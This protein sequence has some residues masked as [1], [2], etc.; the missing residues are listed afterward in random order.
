[1]SNILLAAP[2][3]S[4]G[5]SFTGSLAAGDMS[6]QNLKDISL[7]KKY[8]TEDL[9]ATIN[10][11]LLSA[12]EIDFVSIVA[13]N[14]TASGSVTIK[15]GTTSAVSDFSTGSLDLITGNDAGYSRKFFAS[16][17]SAQTYR[18]WQLSFSDASNTDGYLEMG[19]VYLSKSFQPNTNASYGMAEGHTDQSRV[20]RTASGGV[21]AVTRT[22]FQVATVELDFA[23]KEEMYGQAF[24][25][26]LSRGKS[27]D[28]V[29]VPDMDDTDYFQKRFVYGKFNEINPIVNTAFG[30]YRKRYRIE[31]IR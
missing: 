18:Y 1:M 25:I 8:R 29:F 5:G 7:Y 10:I 19:R 28:V 27:G 15:A 22:P 6:L 24:D 16:K 20:S 13:H 9:S 21:S 12:K 4:D 2:D 11:D 14:A 31:E 17:F 23:T 26:D 3:I 30:I